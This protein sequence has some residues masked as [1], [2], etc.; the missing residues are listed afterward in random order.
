MFS[1]RLIAHRGASAHSP[2]NTIRAFQLA[3]D[4]G[5]QWVECDVLLT[6]CGVPLLI[7]DD[8]LDRTTNG[9]GVV[10][11]HTYEQLR[12]L[13]AGRWFAPEFSGECLPTLA[14]FQNCLIEKNLSANIE[15]KETAQPEKLARAVLDVLSEFLLQYPDR[16]IFSS[17]DVPTLLAL[18]ALNSDV[19]IGLLMETWLPNWEALARTLNAFSIHTDKEIIDEVSAQ[20]VKKA[21]YALF[22]YTVNQAGEA[23]KLFQQGV[24]AVFS[25]HP[26]LLD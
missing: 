10:S 1:S 26:K 2:E 8:T 22:C 14:E 5:A 4:M 17:F 23:E 19:K 11:E 7:H 15:L 16:I 13:D 6:Q 24:D 9:R 18:R 3:A 21:G 25:D 12:S 20:R